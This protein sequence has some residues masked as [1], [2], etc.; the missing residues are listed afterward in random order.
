[1]SR[2]AGSFRSAEQQSLRMSRV[3]LTEKSLHASRAVARGEVFPYLQQ[4]GVQNNRPSSRLFWTLPRMGL[5]ADPPGGPLQGCHRTVVT[6]KGLV[7]LGMQ[8]ETNSKD[9]RPHALRRPN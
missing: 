9:Q 8:P 5:I 3:P 7:A 2:Y 6:A 4:H 1:M